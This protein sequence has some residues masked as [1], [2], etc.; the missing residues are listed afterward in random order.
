MWREKRSSSSRSKRSTESS[1]Q[2]EEAT[3]EL[4]EKKLRKRE[5]GKLKYFFAIIDTDSVASASAI[6]KNLDGQEVERTG[7]VLDLRFVPDDI[8]FEGS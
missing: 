2:D 3:L 7:N 1:D 4:D 6:Y 8:S 5:F